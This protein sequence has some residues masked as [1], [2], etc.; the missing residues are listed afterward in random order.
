MPPTIADVACYHFNVSSMTWC[1]SDSNWTPCQQ[2]RKPTNMLKITLLPCLFDKKYYLYWSI[3]L[4]L[5]YLGCKVSRHV[6]KI[7]LSL[8][9]ILKSFIEVNSKQAKPHLTN[10]KAGEPLKDPWWFFPR[11][12][13][14]TWF[15]MFEMDV[16][17]VWPTLIVESLWTRPF[18]SKFNNY[19]MFWFLNNES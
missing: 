14:N 12:L 16:R 10:K 9:Y 3:P 2:H 19:Y 15:S 13:K 6:I 4:S 8:Y 18:K 5:T 11:G 1:G 7:L 17:T